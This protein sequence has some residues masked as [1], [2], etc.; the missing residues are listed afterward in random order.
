MSPHRLAFLLLGAAM[1]GGAASPGS[2]VADEDPVLKRRFES[3]VAAGYDPLTAPVEW[4]DR[5]IVAGAPRQIAPASPSPSLSP[6]ALEAAAAWAEK[7]GS[8]SLIVAHD[9][10]VVFERYWHGDGRDTRFNPQSMSKTL[11]A[12]LIGSALQAGE[13]R[14][15]DDPVG[16]Y[17]REWRNDS[18][19]RIT[20]KQLLQM[21]SGL[22]QITGDFGYRVTPENPAVRQVFGSDFVGPMLGLKAQN[23]PGSRF[24]YNNNDALLLALVLERATRRRYGTL[25]SDRLWKPLGLA[26][27]ALYVDRPGG[28]PM[29]SCCVFSRPIDWVR[30][31][32]LILDRGRAG[33]R[34]LV[35][36]AWIDAMT[37]ASPNYEGYGYLTWLGDQ[38]VGGK[39]D[40]NE[41]L[42]PWQSEAFEDPGIVFLLGHG[43]QRTWVLPSKR[44]VI[45]RAG[46]T[47]PA[48]WDEA[49]I[50][51]TIWRGTD[52]LPGTKPR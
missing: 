35:P 45:V 43:M 37:T 7:Q 31:G 27:A 2:P 25:L 17:V 51:N 28:F 19:G 44:L 18:R 38:K 5:E 11:T 14:S 16:R 3:F 34:Q 52:S 10:N 41:V 48:S 47:W 49:L 12:L 36:A 24:E 50:P 46:R 32:Q 6:A 33:N 30:I 22:A 26:D 21:S 40:P 23:E 20:I 29:T 1:L 13:I 9:G 42:I 15:I 4:Y 8:T 39:P